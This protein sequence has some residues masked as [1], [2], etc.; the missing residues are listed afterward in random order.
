[1][2]IFILIFLI[3]FAAFIQQGFAQA[4]TVKSRHSIEFLDSIKAAFQNTANDSA[5][6]STHSDAPYR[7]IY[8]QRGDEPEEVEEEI[9]KAKPGTVLGPF[10]SD[11][12][13]YLFKVISLDSNIYRMR[14]SH[15]FIKPKGFKAKDSTDA[16]AAAS[17]IAK[18]LN[19]GE[20]F[21][22]LR[23]EGSDFSKL[24]PEAG[25]NE[26]VEN[27]GHLGWVWEG[28]ATPS[29]DFALLNAKVGEAVVAKSKYGVHV[30]KVSAK[31]RGYY[32]AKIISIT[33]KSI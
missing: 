17:R 27:K 29:I 32:K 18:A 16:F 24:A 10:R 4:L 6:V 1:M 2:R 31:E 5:F 7:F 19:K 3:A 8:L 11:S 21:N 28:T 14:V 25:L 12:Y 33:K 20:D 9:Y 15:I 13:N 26:T 30:L 23:A 22:V